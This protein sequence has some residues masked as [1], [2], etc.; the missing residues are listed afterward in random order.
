MLF[1]ELLDDEGVSSEGTDGTDGGKEEMAQ[2]TKDDILSLKES[3]N[4][5]MERQSS[6]DGVEDMKVM[7]HGD[8][9]GIGFDAD[10]VMEI[11]DGARMSTMDSEQNAMREMMEQM[12]QELSHKQ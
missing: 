5:F 8:G 2:Q 9:D 4:S 11:L 6:I 1:E 12:D 3:M 7:D 10:L